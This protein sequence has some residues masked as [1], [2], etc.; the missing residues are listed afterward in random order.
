MNLK[1]FYEKD[2][3]RFNIWDYGERSKR[4][5]KELLR[6]NFL[7]SYIPE[8]KKMLDL[9]CGS[10]Y[11]SFL[12]ARQGNRVTALDISENQHEKF[13][14]IAN[15]YGIEQIVGDFL[16][17]DLPR[18][19]GIV[20]QEVLEHIPD[21]RVFLH[22]SYEILEKDGFALFCVPYNEDLESKTYYCPYCLK[23]I[24][25]IGHLHKFTFESL[26]R[27]LREVG[28]DIMDIF[29]LCNKRTIKF[30][31]KFNF[32]MCK[33]FIKLDK[34]LSWWNPKKSGYIAAYVQK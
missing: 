22:K 8:N 9:G 19:E 15:E 20:C 32:K 18:F 10:G 1:P 30:M 14:D 25:L 7:L 29:L 2:A 21:Y 31:K 34:F 24:N 12:M 3:T 33:A 13:K 23:K 16:E 4:V 5:I 26:D 11:M 28:Y 6:Y 17:V 27:D